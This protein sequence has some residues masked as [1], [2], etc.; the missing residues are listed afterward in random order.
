MQNTCNRNP[1]ARHDETPRPR[2]GGSLGGGTLARPRLGGRPERPHAGRRRAVPPPPRRR[3][4]RV[5]GPPRVRAWGCGC[6]L[7]LGAWVSWIWFRGDCSCVW[8]CAFVF[9]LD[10]NFVFCCDVLDLSFQLQL[11]V[12][13]SLFNFE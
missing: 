8:P 2:L 10:L 1:P 5:K 4:V 11:W 6:G 7:G 13:S 9:F 12:L 3:P